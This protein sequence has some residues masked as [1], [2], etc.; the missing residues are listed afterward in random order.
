MLLSLS[1][2]VAPPQSPKQSVSPLHDIVGWSWLRDRAYAVT[3][4]GVF[5]PLRASSFPILLM[6][7]MWAGTQLRELHGLAIRFEI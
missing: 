2:H 3:D 4:C 6:G 7:A 1:D 5:A